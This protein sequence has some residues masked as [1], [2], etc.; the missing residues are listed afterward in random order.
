MIPRMKICK[1]GPRPFRASWPYRGYRGYIGV[2]YWVLGYIL[3]LY[4]DNGTEYGNYYL[5]FRDLGF[6]DVGFK[7][8]GI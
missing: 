4:G 1:S 3:G 6:E 5:G 7:G 2:I 8:L